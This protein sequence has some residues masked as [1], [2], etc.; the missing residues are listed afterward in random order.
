M[1]HAGVRGGWDG[2][3][4]GWGW[5][6]GRATAGEQCPR[7]EG[8]RL[9]EKYH[10]NFFEFSE[11]YNLGN[12]ALKNERFHQFKLKYCKII[13]KCITIMHIHVHIQMQ[14]FIFLCHCFV[15]FFPDEMQSRKRSELLAALARRL[16]V[17]LQLSHDIRVGLPELGE[18]LEHRDV[19]D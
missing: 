5:A 11:I 7:E 14:C 17:L 18:A 9:F 12:W 1:H 19:E 8:R 10:K 15:S 16:L 2:L 3:P 6:G 4:G 13:I